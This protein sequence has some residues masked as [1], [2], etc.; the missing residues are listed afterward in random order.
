MVYIYSG[1]S[2]DGME[3]HAI[4][5]HNQHTKQTKKFA[6]EK[7]DSHQIST[8]IILIIN[9]KS[10]KCRIHNLL[11]SQGFVEYCVVACDKKYAITVENRTLNLDKIKFY[12]FSLPNYKYLTGKY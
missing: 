6:Y 5:Q 1:F 3:A 8:T 2:L 9:I 11:F 7:G 12:V 10:L 4:M